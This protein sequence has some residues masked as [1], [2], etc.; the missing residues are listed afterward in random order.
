M[1]SCLFTVPHGRIAVCGMVPQHG[2]SSTEGIHNLFCLI[3]K[4][5]VHIEDMSEGLE[6]VPAAFVGLFADKKVGKQAVQTYCEEN[7]QRIE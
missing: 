7:N 6:S 1:V 4:Q 2:D 5:I 3:T